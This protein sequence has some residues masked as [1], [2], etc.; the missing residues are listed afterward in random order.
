MKKLNGT[1]PLLK[2]SKV[3][4]VKEARRLL[5]KIIECFCKGTLDNKDAKD[6]CYILSVFITVIKET[7]FDERLQALEE[8]LIV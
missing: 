4:N 2:C 8:K 5:S 6:L 7:E 3:T 1:L